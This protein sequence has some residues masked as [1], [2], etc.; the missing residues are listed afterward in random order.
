MSQN[1]FFPF[2]IAV[3]IAK[4]KAFANISMIVCLIPVNEIFVYKDQKTNMLVKI[5]III[6]P[7]R[8]FLPLLLM[9][10]SLSFGNTIVSA[11]RELRFNTLTGQIEHNIANGSPPLLYFPNEVVFLGSRWRMNKL[12]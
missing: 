5:M 4:V 10:L 7:C 11:G 6:V 9:F 2:V 12:K 3:I 1:A 8:I